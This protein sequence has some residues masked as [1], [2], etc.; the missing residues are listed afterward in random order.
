[1]KQNELMEILEEYKKSGIDAEF[2][3]LEV[4]VDTFNYDEIKTIGK[5]VISVDSDADNFIKSIRQFTNNIENVYKYFQK[6]ER[7]SSYVRK[8]SLLIDG[9]VDNSVDICV[10]DIDSNGLVNM[11]F[12]KGLNLRDHIVE[13]NVSISFSSDIVFLIELEKEKEK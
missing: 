1:M 11:F 10:S 12:R 3:K 8:P 6:I 5:V 13:T 9:E 4:F 2:R 7:L